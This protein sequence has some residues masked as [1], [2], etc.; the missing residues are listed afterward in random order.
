MADKKVQTDRA[1]APAADEVQSLLSDFEQ[2]V[3]A[4]KKLCTA[5]PATG[6]PD[7]RASRVRAVADMTSNPAAHQAEVETG[8]RV[9]EELQ[10][11]IAAVRQEMQQQAAAL[12]EHR[13]NASAELDQHR[14]RL[15][16]EI[17]QAAA[18]LKDTT[19]QELAAAA[20]VEAIRTNAAALESERAQVLA[21]A[22]EVTAERAD[23]ARARRNDAACGCK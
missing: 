9:L 3:D 5:R 19:D 15:A 6:T 10:S 1:A 23:G 11:Q 16:A 17:A 22:T 12:E 2:S 18:R 21:L 14:A 20:R 13:R 7:S 4:L 8:R